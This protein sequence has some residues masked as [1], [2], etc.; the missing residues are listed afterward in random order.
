MPET[1][2]LSAAIKKYGPYFVELQG[3][4]L[5]VLIVFVITGTLGG[6][7]SNSI[8]GFIMRQ[9][10]LTGISLVLTSPYQVFEL[11][12]QTGLF[13]GSFCAIPLF[14]FH[15]LTFLKPALESHEYRLLLSLIPISLLL[16]I[17]GFLFGS[18]IM[19]FIIRIFTNATKEYAVGGIWDLSLFFT[20]I[21]SSAL[22]LGLAFEFPIILTILLRFKIV[23]RAV[24][25]KK[26]P[27]VYALALI[28]AAM[29]PPTDPISLVILTVPLFFLFEVTLLLNRSLA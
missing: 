14:I 29:L 23:K 2:A 3:K 19:N 4:L 25:I 12:I 22:L 17:I 8:L 5:Q 21:L 15:I 10:N 7:Y 18:W 26:R 28:G 13:V 1:D 24:L 6:I 20:Q 16:F 27:L 9:F 11:A